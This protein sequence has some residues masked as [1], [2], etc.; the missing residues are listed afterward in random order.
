MKKLVLLSVL[1]AAV[2]AFGQGQNTPCPA[3]L[4]LC[5]KA[6][7]VNQLTPYTNNPGTIAVISD[8]SSSSDCTTGGGANMVT[9]QTN[10]STWSQIAGGGGGGGDNITS[11]NSTLNV[12]GTAANTTLDLK[13]AAGKIMAGATP[14]LTATP[15]LGLVGTTG[16]LTFAGT[17][18]GSAG[19]V[20]P[21]VR[22]KGGV[23]IACFRPPLVLN[24]REGPKVTITFV[25]ARMSAVVVERP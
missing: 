10:G 7:K 13:G 17:T 8:G 11:P 12:G 14:A 16:S 5:G 24:V 4:A 25:N 1:F 9:C 23:C 2:C 6:L 3:N 22:H 19:I 21:S 20:H 15:I 18:S